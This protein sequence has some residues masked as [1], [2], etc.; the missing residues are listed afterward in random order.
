LSANC[1]SERPKVAKNPNYH[2]WSRETSLW[3]NNLEPQSLM[4]PLHHRDSQNDTL[5]KKLYSL[6]ITPKVSFWATEGREESQEPFLIKRNSDDRFLMNMMYIGPTAL[7]PLTK[8]FILTAV[9]VKEWVRK[10]NLINA[11]LWQCTL[12]FM[13]KRSVSTIMCY[14][15]IRHCAARRN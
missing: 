5:V 6:W 4:I 11:N 2:P 13:P 1:H 12:N 8:R 15:F 7:A 3:Q 14:L 9:L 10:E